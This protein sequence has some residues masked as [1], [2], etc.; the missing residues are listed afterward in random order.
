MMR[1]RV[2]EELG[3]RQL[4]PDMERCGSDK[5]RDKASEYGRQ[6]LS[7][8]GTG[9]WYPCPN[10]EMSLIIPDTS[11]RMMGDQLVVKVNINSCNWALISIRGSLVLWVY[12]HVADTLNMVLSHYRRTKDNL[13]SLP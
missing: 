11:V 10:M 4:S 5:G 8:S 3:L 9:Y 13:P 12:Y 6:Q 7:M 2:D 1:A